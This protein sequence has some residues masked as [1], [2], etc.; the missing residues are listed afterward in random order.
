MKGNDYRL[1]VSIFYP[2]VWSYV[3][4]V[5]IH[6]QYDAIDVNTVESN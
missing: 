3:K 2:I 6:Q 4:F 5:G 1:I